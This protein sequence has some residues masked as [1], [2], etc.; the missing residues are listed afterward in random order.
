MDKINSAIHILDA[1]AG[2]E[3]LKTFV[4]DSDERIDVRIATY[5][6][7]N[8]A[9]NLSVSALCKKFRMSR[10]ELYLFFREYFSSSVA[11]FI[12]GRRLQKARQLLEQTRL[13]VGKIAKQCGI[14]DYNYFSKQFKK[15]FDISPSSWRKLYN[16]R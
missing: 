1:C 5:I 9:S 15:T 2:Y 11:D 4:S 16:P 13:P 12:K 10:S 6:E 8:L 14:P 3:Y 7:E